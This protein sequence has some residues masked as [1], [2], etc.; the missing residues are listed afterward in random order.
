MEMLTYSLLLSDAGVNCAGKVLEFSIHVQELAFLGQGVRGLAHGM[1]G[2]STTQQRK[3]KTKKRERLGERDKERERVCVWVCV[4]VEG[5]ERVV[6]R[7][8]KRSR[9]RS[10]EREQRGV[11]KEENT[12]QASTTNKAQAV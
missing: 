7:E 12:K 9:E 11:T 10:R 1:G 8:V 6:K 5:R 2:H 3:R 4:F